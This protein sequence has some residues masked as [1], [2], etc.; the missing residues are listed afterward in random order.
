[1]SENINQ[2]GRLPHETK[3]PQKITTVSLGALNAHPFAA[4]LP[5]GAS[6]YR[7]EQGAVLV[8]VVDNN[9]LLFSEVRVDAQP[10][11]AHI[12]AGRRPWYLDA[13]DAAAKKSKKAGE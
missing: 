6:I 2:R 9:P 5:P 11:A 10:D 13:L 1:M 3:E 4:G 12:A 7:N 8:R